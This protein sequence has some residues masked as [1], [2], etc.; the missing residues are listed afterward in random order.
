MQNGR[1]CGGEAQQSLLSLSY[2]CFM[3]ADQEGDIGSMGSDLE[4]WLLVRE[5][6]EDKWDHC[7]CWFLSVKKIEI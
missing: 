6:L 4:L 2:C 1:A 5:L 3:L 7:G